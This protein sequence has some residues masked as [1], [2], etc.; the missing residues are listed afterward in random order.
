MDFAHKSAPNTLGITTEFITACL[1]ILDSAFII[2]Q[3]ILYK[4]PA[5][6]LWA[7][8]NSQVASSVT[9]PTILRGRKAAGN[10]MHFAEN[11]NHTQGSLRSCQL[12]ALK[13]KALAD[14][15]GLPLPST[16]PAPPSPP[17]ALVKGNVCC[18]STQSAHFDETFIQGTAQLSHD[19]LHRVTSASPSME[20]QQQLWHRN[21]RES[22][23]SCSQ[24]PQR[25]PASI[26]RDE[27]CTNKLL[28]GKAWCA[29]GT[30]VTQ[31]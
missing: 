22:Q 15:L 26:L 9:K 5:S 11:W 21:T 31:W 19:Y 4:F 24:I 8:Q 29:I 1:Q 12:L 6:V 16:Q 30:L 28:Q 27:G 14:L 2:R 18:S 23:G 7:E 10:S 17:A 13:H 25:V 20:N 3:W